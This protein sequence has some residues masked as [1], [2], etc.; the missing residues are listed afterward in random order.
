MTRYGSWFRWC[1]IACLL[2]LLFAFYSGGFGICDST[3]R[4][5][6][7]AFQEAETVEEQSQA[8]AQA[9]LT[10]HSAYQIEQILYQ[11]LRHLDVGVF[12]RVGRPLYPGF[13]DVDED[14]FYLYD[15]QVRLLAESFHKGEYVPLE[16]V[17]ALWQE[18]GLVVIAPDAD[19]YSDIDGVTVEKAMRRLRHW[20]EDNPDEQQGFL[21]RFID[22]LA[23]REEA[24]FDLLEDYAP[25]EETEDFQTPVMAMQEDIRSQMDEA[26][27]GEE[28]PEEFDMERMLDAIMSG[29][30]AEIMRAAVGDEAGAEMEEALREMDQMEFEP[31]ADPE[32]QRVLAMYQRSADLGQR[33][34]LSL[35]QDESPDPMGLMDDLLEQQRVTAES[36]EAGYRLQEKQW[37]E[38]LRE[39]N[40]YLREQDADAS[41]IGAAALN[42]AVDAAALMDHQWAYEEVTDNLAFLEAEIEQIREEMEREENS[43]IEF[44]YDEEDPPASTLVVDPIQAFLIQMDI[45]LA[46][47]EETEEGL[48]FRHMGAGVSWIMAQ[49]SGQRSAREQLLGMLGDR[50]QAAVDTIAWDVLKEAGGESIRQLKRYIDLP[51]EIIDVLHGVAVM[52]AHTVEIE[53]TYHPDDAE[54]G[55]GIRLR[56]ADERSRADYE[57]R[58]IQVKVQVIFDPPEAAQ[59]VEWGRMKVAQFTQYAPPMTAPW[60]LGH[61]ALDRLSDLQFPEAGPQENAVVQIRFANALRRFTRMDP[62]EW[63]Q[64]ASGLVVTDEDGT[65]I[66][67]F[68]LIEET[69]PAA[70]WGGRPEWE[71]GETGAW[72]RAHALSQMP[73]GGV[74]SR[75]D[76]ILGVADWMQGVTGLGATDSRIHIER[77]KPVPW[78]GWVRF[79]RRVDVDVYAG[80]DSPPRDSNEIRT[81]SYDVLHRYTINADSPVLRLEPDSHVA[82]Q[83]PWEGMDPTWYVK[84]TGRHAFTE[85]REGYDSCPPCSDRTG[86]TETCLVTVTRDYEGKRTISTSDGSLQV[87]PRAAI[88]VKDGK[89]RVAALI[90]LVVPPGQ[91]LN[92]VRSTVT[93]ESCEGTQRDSAREASL[94]SSRSVVLPEVVRHLT[95]AWQDNPSIG[96]INWPEYDRFTDRL[97]GSIS[98]HSPVRNA[99]F[100]FLA[101]PRM[102]VTN[103]LE[104][105]FTRVLDP[106]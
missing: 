84:L 98:W 76:V 54:M 104:W 89:Y 75:K 39:T 70:I 22:H 90:P 1:S 83:V 106:D 80:A 72:I 9:L 42:I 7:Q 68:R 43:R 82:D 87:S 57:N 86:V 2:V 11:L 40:S 94:T 92:T 33:L 97:E 31:T 77:V 52:A 101:R 37:E 79:E 4:A 69:E 93:R 15:F 61:Y 23:D 32:E 27:E 26:M 14:D 12:D 88:Q 100:F 46:Q 63:Y 62:D 51:G 95:V 66:V 58:Y 5:Q 6:S 81:V 55:E 64:P 50:L 73:D 10:A 3:A 29:N 48:G 74:W 65:A 17:I 30:M 85:V 44:P 96:R 35:L 78:V 105:Q 102:E 53:I 20:A 13:E 49:N 71:F 34:G 19:A 21:I 99:P 91:F 25:Y 36:V 16:D 41:A 18:A 103:T 45:I 38:E 60:L 56:T 28:L 67:K 24:P 8:L 47:G 59:N